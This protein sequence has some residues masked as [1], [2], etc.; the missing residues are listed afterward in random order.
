MTM[1][2]LLDE[3]LSLPVED[4]AIL[5]DTLLRSLNVPDP[6]NDAVWVAEAKRRLH[7]MRSGASDAIPGEQVFDEIRRRFTK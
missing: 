3:A 4:R 6:A 7:A 2:E 1:K 5:A